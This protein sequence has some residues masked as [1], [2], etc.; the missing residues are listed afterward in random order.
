MEII[1]AIV[2]LGQY[3]VNGQCSSV[4]T[5]M[6]SLYSMPRARMVT[7]QTQPFAT[8][9][10]YS[11]FAA[12]VPPAYG[13]VVTNSPYSFQAGSSGCYNSQSAM[14]SYQAAPVTAGTSC[15]SS[16]PQTVV[17]QAGFTTSFGTDSTYLAPAPMLATSTEVAVFER[18]PGILRRTGRFIFGER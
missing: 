8:H 2:L 17:P 6:R 1:C 15:Y 10:T 11:Q 7:V 9:Q 16:V 14:P 12:P 4:T 13:S 18:E 3:C 5:S